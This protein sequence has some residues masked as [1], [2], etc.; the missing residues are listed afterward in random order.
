MD[1]DKICGQILSAFVNDMPQHRIY[2]YNEKGWKN[3]RD[4]AEL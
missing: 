2:K 1:M 3:A 4:E